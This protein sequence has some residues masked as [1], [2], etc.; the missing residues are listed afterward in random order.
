MQRPFTALVCLAVLAAFW[1]VAPAGAQ[2]TPS[3]APTPSASATPVPQTYVRFVEADVLPGERVTNAYAPNLTGRITNRLRAALEFKFFGP[4]FL[5]LEYRRWDADHPTG[6]VTQPL[7]LTPVFVPAARY[8]EQDVL[9]NNS[10]IGRGHTYLATST[11]MHSSN[12]GD[13]NLHADLG[14]GVERLPDPT[15]SASLFFSYYYYP[16]VTGKIGVPP[17]APT[18]NLRYK[19][20]NYNVG[21]TLGV[22]NTPMFVTAGVVADHYLRKQNAASNAKHV[23]TQLGLGAHF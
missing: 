15:R 5:E 6:F 16:E 10:I 2:I 8:T 11:L 9:I 13:P 21:G 7:T 1:A 20:E 14:F 17:G 3:P 22:P 12:D 4:N 19:V 23:S 18:A